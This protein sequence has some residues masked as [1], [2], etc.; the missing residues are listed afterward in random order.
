MSFEVE[1]SGAQQVE[2]LLNELLGTSKFG[3]LID[4]ELVAGNGDDIE[5]INP[6]TGQVFLIYRDAGKDIVANA[7][8]AAIKAQKVWWSMT[9]SARGQLMWQC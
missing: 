9:A 7:A 2:I 5:L 8:D 3:S 6:A 1:G 4:G